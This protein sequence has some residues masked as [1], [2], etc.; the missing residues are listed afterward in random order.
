MGTVNLICTVASLILA[1]VLFIAK[2]NN[3]E[4][5]EERLNK[6][7]NDEEVEDIFHR[8]NWSK[9]AASLLTILAAILFILTE[10][11]RLP[12][13][14]TDK[15]TILHV[16]GLIATLLVFARGLHKEYDYTITYFLN[17]EAYKVETLKYDDE[18]TVETPVQEGF[19]FSGWDVELPEKMPKENLEVHGTM[20]AA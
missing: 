2:K 3:E 10:D 5:E 7:N 17:G 9:W 11:V 14:L 15:W 4:D 19:R 1:L 18:I 20:M 8:N 13:V 12:M 16:V 6:I